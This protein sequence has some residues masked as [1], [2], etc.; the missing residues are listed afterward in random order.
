MASD[1]FNARTDDEVLAFIIEGRAVDHH[2]NTTGV[3]MPPRGGYPNISDEQ[4][5]GIIAY[6]RTIIA[7]G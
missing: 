2:D 4:I 5:I 6:L 1:F 3:A 7:E